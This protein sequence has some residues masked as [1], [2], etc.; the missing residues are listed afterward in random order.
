M[1]NI[2]IPKTFMGKNCKE[3]YEKMMSKS[4]N[5]DLNLKKDNKSKE[6]I[7]PNQD[8]QF[9]TDKNLYKEIIQYLNTIFPNNQN[10]LG[11][12]KLKFEDNVMKGSNIYNTIAIDMYLK[13]IN[14]RYRIARQIDLEQ[15]LDMFKEFYVDSGL[16]LRN[17]T[18]VYQQQT[19]YLFEQLKSRG[20]TEDDFPI[21]FDL[22]GLKLDNNLIF[23]LTDESKY[24]TA[25]CLNW[26]DDEYYSEID[27]FGL[28]K[29][30]NENS[31][32]KI[33]TYNTDLARCY[34]VRSSILS[35]SGGMS[36][37]QSEEEGYGRIVLANK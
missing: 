14:S 6:L 13:S 7:L 37:W 17:L 3:E 19:K 24:K 29:K 27:D 22:R 21:W 23:N 32:R 36:F 18:G 1:Q 2:K 12:D 8:L 20:L 11:L 10:Y 35:T 5:K 9:I 15:K 25:K 31:N 34:L 16:A 30:I 33:V 28:P 4:P 26:E